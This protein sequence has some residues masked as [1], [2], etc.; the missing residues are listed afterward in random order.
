MESQFIISLTLISFHSL[1]P[2]SYSFELYSTSVLQFALLL[3]HPHLR[4]FPLTSGIL[5]H[6]PHFYSYSIFPMS[7]HLYLPPLIN[8]PKV[9]FHLITHWPKMLSGSSVPINK[10]FISQPNIQRAPESTLNM[11]TLSL[12]FLHVTNCSTHFPQ[13]CPVHLHSGAH[14]TL[15]SWNAYLLT[16]PLSASFKIPLK[17]YFLYQALLNN[18]PIYYSQETS[19]T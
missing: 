16:C 14:A 17:V 1:R 2:S 8:L 7:T 5:L 13:P 3:P 9:L 11:L 18:P 4:T 12:V 19:F 15:I 6:L 10:S